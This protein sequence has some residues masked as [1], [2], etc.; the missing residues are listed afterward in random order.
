M[1][2]AWRGAGRACG[3]RLLVLSPPYRNP[4]PLVSVE[5]GVN[6]PLGSVVFGDGDGTIAVLA[7]LTALSYRAP[8]A[9][10]CLALPARQEPLE[11]LLLLVSELRD[12]LVVVHRSATQRVQDWAQL[13][14][15]VRRRAAPTPAK[16]ARW[17]ARRLRQRELEVPLRHQFEE[18]LQGTPA[19]IGLSVASYSRLFAQYGVYTARDW[20][21]L[22]RLAVHAT[23]RRLAERKASAQISLRTA[24]EYAR[25]YL[26]VPYHVMAER[27]GWEWVLEAALRTASYTS[28]AHPWGRVAASGASSQATHNGFAALT[29][30]Q[31]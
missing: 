24:C 9:I 19:D 21:A 5:R 28:A 30:W 13:A 29:P 15:H 16:L 8:W 4:T 22:G 10:P 23:S 27:L 7:S 6:L 2:R 25:R 1:V 20:R 11:P 14:R 17:V 18:A 26:G 12:R 3:S 31:A